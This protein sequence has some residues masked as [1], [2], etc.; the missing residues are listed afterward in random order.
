MQEDVQ[1]V[2]GDLRLVK[3]E[4]KTD[5]KELRVELKAEIKELRGELK[6]EAKEL[7]QDMYAMGKGIHQSIDDVL[8]VLINIDKRLTGSVGDHEKRITKLEKQVALAA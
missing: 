5:I 6:A 3:G 2:N 1:A 7:R 8:V 4:L